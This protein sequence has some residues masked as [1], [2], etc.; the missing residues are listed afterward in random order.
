MKKATDLRGYEHRSVIELK[1]VLEL[2]QRINEHAPQVRSDLLDRVSRVD[3]QSDRERAV[4]AWAKEWHLCNREGPV[5]WAMTIGSATAE[6]VPE[7][8]WN[9]ATYLIHPPD[10][11][12][13]EA[14]L[15]RSGV[16]INVSPLTMTWRQDRE[17][18]AKFEK[19]IVDIVLRDVRSQMESG[20]E[21]LRD[22]L[23]PLRHLDPDRAFTFLMRYQVLEERYSEIAESPQKYRKQPDRRQTYPVPDVKRDIA[24]AV[25]QA[26][27][28]PRSS[29]RGRPRNRAEQK[30][31]HVVRRHRR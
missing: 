5:Q 20:A 31:R 15:N 3:D 14:Y 19:R 17:S 4:A 24:E 12:L 21:E 6:Q 23:G 8:G 1:A 16:E 29:Q 18:P 2:L 27:L 22:F 30:R 13:S 11:D 25:R 7:S 26:G 9:L 10:S 28:E